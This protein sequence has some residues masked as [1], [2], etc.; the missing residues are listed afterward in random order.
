MFRSRPSLD[1]SHPWR[2]RPHTREELARGLLKG[3]IAGPAVSH[4]RENVRWKVGRLVEGDPE[5]QFGLRGLSRGGLS[6][7]QVLAMM[8]AEA[9]FDPD[10][11]ITDGP[12]PVDPD[13]VLDR[14]LAA[15]RRLA[16]A[17]D[18][19]ERVLLATGH[20][21]GLSLLYMAVGNLLE[22]RGAKLVRPA[23]G[24]SWRE[25][26]RH[27]EIRYLHGVAVLTDRGS[28]MHTH[29]PGPMERILSDGE[30]DL[31]LADHGF[32]GAAIQAGIDT[33]SVA[34]VNDPAPVV[35]KWAGRTET[36][37]VMDDNVQP[38]DYWPCFQAIAAQFPD[39]VVGRPE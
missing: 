28:T 38:E 21:A 34:D 37:I 31:V 8:G 16:L 11:A 12:V 13:H 5:L 26:G 17:A 32:A 18:R 7:A 33:L 36:V 30:P 27:R 4:D 15:G 1:G 25:G 23:W 10:P 3:R 22:R 19:G 20:P 14:L 9:G 2:P 29:S 6:V 35:A 39:V 24:E